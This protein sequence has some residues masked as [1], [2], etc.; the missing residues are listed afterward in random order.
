M[1]ENYMV[2]NG[3]KIEFTP[4]QLKPLGIRERLD[5]DVNSPVTRYYI[6]GFGVIQIATNRIVK[7]NLSQ[8]GNLFVSAG[9]V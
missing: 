7:E 4:E 3:R 9:E 6:D 1:S 8:I 2:I 5:W